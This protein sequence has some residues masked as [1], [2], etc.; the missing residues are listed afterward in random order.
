MQS[1]TRTALLALALFASLGCESRRQM[2][3]NL[4][5]EWRGG[6][7]YRTMC[8]V[9]HGANGEGYAA[10]HAPRLAGREF[11]ATTTDAMLR[12]A[13]AQGRSGTTMSAWGVGHGGPLSPADLDLL[14]TFMRLWQPRAPEAMLDEA[15]LAGDAQRGD[16]IYGRECS[17]CHGAHG[18]AGPEVHVG[19]SDFLSTVTNGY[20]RAAIAAGRSRTP[21]P[22]FASTLGPKGVDDVIALFRSWQAS[23]PPVVRPAPAKPPPLPLGRVPLNPRGP[24]PVGFH[25]GTTTPADAIKGELSKGARMALLD[26]RAPSDYVNE[27]IAGAV[28]VPFYDPAPYIGRLPKDIWYVCYCACPHAE[29]GQLAVK[30]AQA[31]FKKVTVLDEG[32]GVWRS[33][34]YGTKAGMEP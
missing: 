5:R 25:P 31:G 27:H 21:M 18:T 2:A 19:S 4:E 32:L 22:A 17:R 15:P 13:I 16:E 23:A 14:V 8:A 34:G 10:D 9:C 7:I 33:R 1:S 28:S 3:H 30:L 11:L 6:E 29:S 12:T 24:E 20:L 26:A